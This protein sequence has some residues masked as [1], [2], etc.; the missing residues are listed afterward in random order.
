MYEVSGRYAVLDIRS[1]TYVT[2]PTP[3]NQISHDTR[4]PRYSLRESSDWYM[5]TVL[6]SMPVPK[7]VMTR[8]MMRCESLNAEVCSEAPTIIRP[9]ASHIIFLR[10]KISPVK[11]LMMHPVR[12]PRQ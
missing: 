2:I 4:R 5:G 8:P 10:P 6:E 3:M 11:K 12:A 9:M 1:D 7:P